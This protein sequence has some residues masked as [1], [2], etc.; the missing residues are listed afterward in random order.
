MRCCFRI[1]YRQAESV[2]LFFGFIDTRCHLGIT[3]LVFGSIMFIPYY[4]HLV[5]HS[6]IGTLAGG[7]W[8]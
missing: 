8:P 7:N 4:A 6:G 3:Y 5:G 1:L 2:I